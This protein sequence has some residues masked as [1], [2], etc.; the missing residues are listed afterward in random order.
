MK[1]SL[2]ARLLFQ[3][4]FACVFFLPSAVV[5]AADNPPGG[6]EW[7]YDIVYPK[8]GDPYRG[9]VV[10]QKDDRLDMKWVVRK[11]GR[12]TIDFSV[13]L[14]RE[15]IDRVDLLPDEERET[16]RRRLK[17]LREERARLAEHLKAL[18]PAAKP[19]AAGAD[20]LDLRE[21]PWVGDSRVKALSY[22]SS[23]FRLVSNAPRGIVVATAIRLEQAYA[24]Y[25]HCLPPRA[26]GVAT[27]ILVPQSMADYRTLVRGQGRNLLNPAFFDPVENQ[28]VCAFDWQHMAEELARVHRHHVKL[29]TDLNEREAELR[30]AYKGVLPA[31]LK[32]TL[33]DKRRQIDAAEARN[34][35]VFERAQQRLFQRLFHE[36]FHAYLLNFVYPNR[37]GELPRW[38][39]EGLAQIFETAIFEVGE[40]RIG[41]AVKE[42]LDAMRRGLSKNTL[43]PLAD[44]L[45]S[46]PKQFQVAH[47]GDKQVSDRYYLLSWA[48]AHYL[49]F[50]RKL[51]GTPALDAYVRDLNRGVDPGDAFAKLTG[52]PLAQFERAF[53]DFLKHLRPDGS[54]GGR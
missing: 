54:I 12:P 38:L 36:A 52:Q 48:L 29:R 26:K 13:A 2:P 39:N 3:A 37:D 21:T 19:P 42:R 40:L 41:H 11:P 33:A 9:L 47:D 24:A 30:K 43:L 14:P 10:A 15:T 23:H 5:F 28:V 1:R 32:K 50:D 53:L 4:F 8:K 6:D 51:L 25:A 35:V 34:R 7:K 27:T 44:L 17:T 20:K 45:R 49:T 18:D 22:H 31:E 46:G 16:L